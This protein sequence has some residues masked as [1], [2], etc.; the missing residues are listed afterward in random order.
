M[1]NIDVIRSMQRPEFQQISLL[2]SKRLV[3]GPFD[4]I[5][6][7]GKQAYNHEGVSSTKIYAIK[8]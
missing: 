5:C 4:V 3:P 2:K 8:C 6:A 7:R 1:I